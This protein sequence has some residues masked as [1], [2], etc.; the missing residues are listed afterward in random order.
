MCFQLVYLV[1]I[2]V[3]LNLAV[4]H[5]DGS[6]SGSLDVSTLLRYKVELPLFMFIFST[7]K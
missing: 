5:V 2:L 3:S 6:M 7:G 4:L 1:F